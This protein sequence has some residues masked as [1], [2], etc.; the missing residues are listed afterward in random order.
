M[1]KLTLSI[2]AVFL[3]SFLPVKES[4]AIPAFARK[5]RL[6]CKTCHTPSSPKLKDYGDSFAGSGFKLEDEE[7]PRYYVPAG[8]DKLSL[9]RD[10]PIAVRLDGHVTYNTANNNGSDIGAPYMLKLLS[11]G[12]LS[13]KLSYYFYFYMNE[14]GEVAGVEDAILMYDNVLGTELDIVIGQFQVSDPLFKRELR[15]SLEDY[16]LYTSEIGMSD[17][18]LKYDRGIVVSYGFET[19]TDIEVSIF[20]G[21]GIPEQQFNLFDKDKHKSYLGRVSQNLG[22]YLRIGGFAYIGKEEQGDGQ[23]QITNDVLIAGPDLTLNFS[24]QLEFN[25]QYTYREDSDTYF[26]RNMT[27]LGENVTTKGIMSELIYAPEA[28]QSDWYLLGL[29]N[30]VESNYEPAE[31]ESL[32]FHA[33]YLIRRNIRLASEYSYVLMDPINGDDYGKFSIGVI[34]AF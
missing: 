32:T 17:I 18:T 3:C 22:E 4:N 8:D 10:F 19:G 15:L 6:S 5:Y 34:S 16:M 20:N 33:G 21:N 23:N 29:Y 24:D 31:Y 13:E 9:I 12:E 28:D 7:A 11:G 25:F 2:I 26:N 1:K 30:R 27:L 14:Q